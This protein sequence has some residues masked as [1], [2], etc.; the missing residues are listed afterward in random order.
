MIA[1]L[2]MVVGGHWAVLQTVAWTT[3][4]ASNLRTDSLETAVTKT[5]DGQH[6]CKLCKV[7]SAA[8]KA[9]KKSEAPAIGKKLEFVSARSALVFS[10]PQDFWLQAELAPSSTTLTHA[11]PLP[12]PRPHAA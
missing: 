3:M 9:E 5:F 12:P 11:P 8:K 7:I 2:I 4:L 6:P 1:A 10:P